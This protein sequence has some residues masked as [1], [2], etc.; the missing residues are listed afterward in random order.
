MAISTLTN[1]QPLPLSLKDRWTRFSRSDQIVLVLVEA[2]VLG[3]C[4][5]LLVAEPPTAADWS[6]VIIVIVLFAFFQ[7]P[8]ALLW[9]FASRRRTR[10]ATPRTT[11][12]EKT[13]NF[14]R[15]LVAWLVLGL[16]YA[17]GGYAAEWMFPE[18]EWATKWRYSLDSEL[19]NATYVTEKHPHDCEFL[20]APMGDKHCHYDKVVNIVRVRNGPSGREISYDGSVWSPAE[21]GARTTVYV[22]WSKVEE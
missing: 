5:A 2:L 6:I 19:K 4:V 17:A 3:L 1:E 18:S 13:A 22:S 10:A 16:L 9:M 20:S 8:V 11:W 21:P 14:G 7:V 15:G 12:R